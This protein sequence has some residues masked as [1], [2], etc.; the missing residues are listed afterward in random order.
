MRCSVQSEQQSHRANEMLLKAKAIQIHSEV[1]LETVVKLSIQIP[2]DNFQLLWSLIKANR[3]RV[4]R[5]GR[6]GVV[7]RQT[8]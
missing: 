7:T 2:Q 1:V 4:V 5:R 8:M 6:E 3:Q